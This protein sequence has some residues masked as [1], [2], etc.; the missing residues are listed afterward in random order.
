MYVNAENCKLYKAVSKRLHDSFA[1]HLILL[2]QP[3]VLQM[4]RN[5]LKYGFYRQNHACFPR[6]YLSVLHKQSSTGFKQRPLAEFH[7][8][9][10]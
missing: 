4:Q 9:K 6:I 3:Y 5:E 2:C 7:G 10:C 8:Q 1:R